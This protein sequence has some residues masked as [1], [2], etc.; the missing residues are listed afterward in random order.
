MKYELLSQE[1]RNLKTNGDSR[2]EEKAQSVRCLLQKPEDP[3]TIPSTHMKLGSK[4]CLQASLW[5]AETED[6]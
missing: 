2:A 6:L 1:G 4:E 3:S 5:G